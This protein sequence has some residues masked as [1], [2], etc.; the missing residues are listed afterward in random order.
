MSAYFLE[1]VRNRY[2]LPTSELNEEFIKNLHVKTGID[3]EEIKD[4]VSFIRNL[5]TIHR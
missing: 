1:H 4:I 5:D 3:E 2:K